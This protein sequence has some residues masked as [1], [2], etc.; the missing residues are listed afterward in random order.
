MT[1]RYGEQFE[2]L[3]GY[4]NRHRSQPVR[5][6]NFFGL[7]APGGWMLRAALEHYPGLKA[8]WA[9]RRSLCFAARFW[10]AANSSLSDES[11]Q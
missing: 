9:E 5:F 1:I 4:H 11:R 8:V 7:N 6:K 10:A 3:F 2:L